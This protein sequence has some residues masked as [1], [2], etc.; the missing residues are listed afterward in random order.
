MVTKAVDE[1]EMVERMLT[2]RQV[3]VVWGVSE[4]R[5]YGMLAAGQLPFVKVGRAIRVPETKLREWI[6]A[7][8]AANAHG[9]QPERETD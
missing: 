3:A 5:V 6:D 7:Q 9:D 8:V 1:R 2:V 4:Q